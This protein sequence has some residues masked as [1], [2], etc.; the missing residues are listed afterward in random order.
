M[1]ADAVRAP[2][3]WES[4]EAIVNCNSC[5][6]EFTFFVR[7]HHCRRDGKIYCGDCT[8]QSVPLPKFGFQTPVR[9]CDRC[10]DETIR[11]NRFIIGYQSFLAEGG[12]LVRYTARE[13]PV[14]IIMKL[15]SDTRRLTWHSTQL[16]RNQPQ[17]FDS[18]S[19][20]SITD[21]ISDANGDVFQSYQNMNHQKDQCF[22]IL[23]KRPGGFLSLDLESNSKEERD[24][25]VDA[26]RSAIDYFQGEKSA[27]A[28]GRTSD[29][30]FPKES[31]ASDLNRREQELLEKER[32]REEDR[33]RRT[34]DIKQK[35]G[36]GHRE[37][38]FR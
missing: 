36:L 16:V 25:W 24:K 32:H 33:K 20:E 15:S 14:P 5:Q 2:A 22:S 1:A 30:V 7:K 23:A 10:Y 18:L 9:V 19:L 35:Y 3:S 34:E 12:M 26:I 13:E 11:E 29:A 28:K 17:S 6:V 38:D 8:T 27:F 4:D 37:Q 21:V 31:R